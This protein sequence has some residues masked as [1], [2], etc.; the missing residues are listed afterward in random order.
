MGVY[1]ALL[2]VHSKV[3]NFL[4]SDACFIPVI[5]CEVEF[6][7][8]QFTEGHVSF[9]VEYLFA[10]TFSKCDTLDEPPTNLVIGKLVN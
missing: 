10:E 2:C 3:G 9:D 4:C 8:E 1:S 6:S 7:Q 5:R